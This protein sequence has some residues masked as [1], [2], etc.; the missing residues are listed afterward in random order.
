MRLNLN[1]VASHIIN[2]IGTI[3]PLELYSAFIS[4]FCGRKWCYS[5]WLDLNIEG[6]YWRILTLTNGVRVPNSTEVF[7]FYSEIDVTSKTIQSVRVYSSVYQ[8]RFE[9]S[10]FFFFHVNVV[11]LSSEVSVPFDQHFTVRQVVENCAGGN[12]SYLKW[13]VDVL[14]SK[15]WLSNSRR[16]ST[17]EGIASSSTSL[18]FFTS[19]RLKVKGSLSEGLVRNCTIALC[20][21]GN[22]ISECLVAALKVSDCDLV[23]GHGSTSVAD[24]LSP[25]EDNATIN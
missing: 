13:L 12:S 14:D 9:L 15:I 4:S 24:N 11:S 23:G 10:F 8:E 18:D 17:V 19:T 16:C 22:A 21:V 20:S 5:L 2:V 3:F 1:L 25:R 7:G 6:S